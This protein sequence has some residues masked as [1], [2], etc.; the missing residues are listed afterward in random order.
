ME[1][2]GAPQESLPSLLKIIHNTNNYA[3]TPN[4]DCAVTL[5]QRDI[6]IYIQTHICTHKHTHTGITRQREYPLRLRVCI[7]TTYCAHYIVQIWNVR[8]VRRPI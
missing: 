6:Y 4:T 3:A 1:V 2:V 8:Y 5:T 7:L